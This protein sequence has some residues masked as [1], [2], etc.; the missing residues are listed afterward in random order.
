MGPPSAVTDYSSVKDAK[1]LL[2][3][4]GE[5]VHKKV[6][7]A[8]KQYIDGLKGNLASSS[9]FGETVA[10]SDPCE[11]IKDEGEKLIKDTGDPCRKDGTGKEVPRFSDKQGAQC[12]YRKIR[13]SKNNTKVG[14]CAPFRRLFL[15][16]KNLEN[17]N[18]N[19]IDNKHN[20]LAEV[21]MAANFEAESLIRYHDQ[22]QLTYGH[23]QLCT[24]LAR[25][26]A[27]IGDIV[28]GKDLYMRNK[29]KDKLEENLKKIFDNIY[30]ELTNGRNGV[31]EHYKEDKETG[32]YYK[33]R[34]DWWTANRETVW[35]ALTCDDKLASA[36]YFRPTCSDTKGQSVARNQCR[37]PNSTN[38]VPTYFDY[39]P[40]F[41]RWFE[42]WTEDFCRKK[43]KKL[44][45]VKTNCRGDYEGEPR[46]CSRNGYDCEQTISR[47]GKVCM[48][49]GCTD[50]FF[51]CDRY[52]KWID[53]QKE[54]FLKQKGK[55]ESEISGNGRKR[56]HAPSSNNY[57]GYDEQFYDEL[58]KG[59]YGDV[60]KFLNLL[61]KENECTNINDTE[62]GKI[63]FSEKHD[64]KNNKGTFYHSQYCQV[65]PDCGVKAVGKGKFQDKDT[66]GVK[67]EG[68]KRYIH[69]SGVGPTEINVLSS[70][71]ANE[72]ITK[73][74]KAFCDTSKGNSSTLYQ[75]WN[76]YYENENNEACILKNK[77]KKSEDKAH[78]I[79][80]SF[81][82]FFEFWVTHMLKDSIDW[83]T[84]LTKCLSNGNPTKCKGGCKKKCEC[85]EKWVKQKKKEWLH[86]KTHFNKQ[87]DIEDDLKFFTL[88]KVLEE[89]FFERIKKAYG[90]DEEID[91]IKGVIQNNP[92]DK[93]V[94]F[95]ESEDIVQ[96]L[97]KHEE[98]EAQKCVT[99]NPDN[100]CKKQPK[101][102][103]EGGPGRSLNEPRV[104]SPPPSDSE[105]EEEDEYH[106]DEDDDDANEV[107]EEPA[108]EL[109]P[110]EEAVPELPGPP[111]TPEMKPCKIVEELFK[112]TK[113]FNAACT[114]KYSGNNPRLGWKCI[115]T[116]GGTDS[117]VTAT[118]SEV[119]S[120]RARDTASVSGPPSGTNQGGLCVPPRRRRL[121]I[122]KLPDDE[123][124]EKSLRKWFIESAAVET[125]FLWDRYKKEWELQKNKPQNGELYGG[126]GASLFS[127]STSDMK[128]VSGVAGGPPGVPG[129]GGALQPLQPQLGDLP[130]SFGQEQPSL[131]LKPQLFGPYGMTEGAVQSIPLNVP[132]VHGSDGDPQTLLQ[133]GHIPNDFLRLMFYTLGDYRDILFGYTNIV[134]GAIS[135]T[136]DKSGKQVMQDI[137]KKIN[138]ILPRSDNESSRGSPQTQHS[139]ENPRKSWWEQHGKHIWEGMVCALTYEDNGA[140]GS[141]SITQDQT[142]YG[143]LLSGE[144]NALKE[145]YQY[146]KVVLKEEESG[147]EAKPFTSE[148]PSASGDNTP[149][150]TEFV[151]RPP[152]FRYLEEWGE[153]FCK[154]RK[155]RLEKIEGEC[156][157]GENDGRRGGK[158]CSGYGEDCHDN[159][160]NKKYDIL[161]SLECPGCGR[162]CRKYKKW[163]KRKRTE[164][165]KQKSAYEEQQK[166]CQTQSESAKQFCGTV[167]TCKTA[168]EFLQ[169]LGPCSKTN[170]ERGEDK[171][172][173]KDIEQTFGHENYCDPCSKFKIDCEKGNCSKDKEEECEKKKKNSIDAKDIETMGQPTDDVSMLVSDERPNGFKDDLTECESA[174]IFK[175]IRKDEWT[176][177][178][179]CGY[180]VCK[181]KN[182]SGQKVNEKSSGE[183]HIIIIRALVTHWVH[184]FLEDYNKI[185][186]KISHCTNNAEGITCINGCDKKCNCVK[187]WIEEKRKEWENIKKRYVKQYSDENMDDVYK[188]KAILEDLQSQIPVTI[189]KAIEPCTDLNK[190][191]DSRD[192]AV[193]V[194]TEKTESSNKKDVVQCLLHRLEK[195]KDKIDKCKDEHVEKSVS[196]SVVNTTLCENS[197]SVEDEDDILDEETEVR[198]PEI[199]KDVVDTKKEN[200]ETEGGC[201][202]PPTTPKEPTADIGE[203]T[204]ELPSPPE[205][206]VKPATPPKQRPR[207]IVKRSLLPPI[208]GASAF[209]WTVGIAFAALSYFVLK[210]KTKSTIDLLRVINIPKGDYDIPTLKSSN[211]YIPYA[212]D[213]YKGKTYIYMEGDSGDEK[214]TGDITSSDITSSESEYEEFDINDIY[215]YKSPKYKT[216]IEVVLEPSKRDTTN[217]PNDISSGGTLTH[218]F[219]DNEWNEL[220]NDFITNILQNEQNDI[221]NNNI[222]A[223]IPLNTHPNTLYFDNPEEKTFIT[224]I[225][226]R[227]LYS[228]EEISYN[229]NMTNNDDIPISGKNDTY[230]GIDLINDSLNSDQHID[231]YDEVLKRK[232]NELFGT[233]H[234]KKNTSTNSVAK[235]T[236][237]DPITNQ[238]ELF[239]KWL[240]RHRNM[241]EKLKNKE[242]ILNKL[243]EEWNKENNNNGDKTYNSDNKPS[244]NHVLNTDVSIQIDMDNPKTKNEITNMDTNPDKSTMDTI[245]DDLE[246]YN[247]PYYYDFYEDDIIYHDV[248]VEKSPMDDIYVDHNNVTS[249]NM[250]VSTKMH[251]E[252]NIVN[253]K[254]EIFEEEYPISDIWNI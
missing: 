107:V 23:S 74:L 15:C 110:E 77:E 154:E 43:K 121:Y 80:K 85:Y 75:E 207:K 181:R 65:C 104:P 41:L 4:I 173:F 143:K 62:G 188:V 221:P 100:D 48:G 198:M 239:H 157:V 99:N 176:C 152:Y 81:Y 63:D 2:D 211:R 29:K 201:E 106:S 238:L 241:C 94:P 108:E 164:Y 197:P 142:A 78:E 192:C 242:D 112:D 89:E 153:N 102:T 237:S 66:S 136:A 131:P 132:G 49:K 191:Q 122:Q 72:D 210:K 133:K 187:A 127:W 225:H 214:Y 120:R 141:T 59:V 168:A 217:T 223:N 227:N 185:K 97:L 218:Q 51:A 54:Q 10:F 236:N 67:C 196:N 113:H 73:K 160:F 5:T 82:D 45:H 47:I 193:S 38:V 42:E 139:G 175:G 147:T 103:R 248:D 186:H 189:K 209:P 245:L 71:D 156:K 55:C 96:I 220:K 204:E 92:Q 117:G 14:A 93:T 70:G 208:L 230:S 69:K 19:N 22:H 235:N 216:L 11:L 149:K 90:N 32:N 146:D 52:E 33:L 35:K 109:Q 219:T 86:I 105:E 101:P 200:D 16:D 244:H 83:R 144:K 183:K 213:R 116:S 61:N 148:P 222:S 250:D 118:D 246:K 206:P 174:G 140:R 134:E 58:K 243:K 194:N 178:N 36:H 115:P 24:V 88:E 150:L 37:C 180:V 203:G 135:G 57:E 46:Y 25:S 226:D 13:D 163:I 167:T 170:D 165:E 79:E 161:P 31:K 199:C 162:E 249:N 56:R 8:A 138:A 145:E 177:G 84:E 253:N 224:K 18:N 9:I 129:E 34:E 40:Q 30:N 1:D 3:K 182:I 20:L 233:N 130:G 44:P 229:I 234:T 137:E 169:K 155:K 76:C 215:P 21:C 60:D 12:D 64:D 28:R 126:G 159:L 252:M 114:Q 26:F 171:K 50:C 87:H 7:E 95:L 39:V 166:K 6:H 111:A 240:D 119:K 158:K 212:S 124:D 179:V 184:N 195:L 190:F 202:P 68:E 27:D 172:I 254:N 232:E 205:L 53:K 17:M 125:F 247:E 251:I 231:I 91:R 128:A 98:E 228:G 151:E 123:F